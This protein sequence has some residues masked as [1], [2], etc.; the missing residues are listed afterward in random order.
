MRTVY[1]HYVSAHFSDACHC[2]VPGAWVFVTPNGFHHGGETREE[3]IQL[4]RDEFGLRVR[5]N[6]PGPE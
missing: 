2:E 5:F 1:A 6:G 3:T 4:A